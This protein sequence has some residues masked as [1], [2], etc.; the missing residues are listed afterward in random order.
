MNE[1]ET[2]RAVKRKFGPSLLKKKGVQGGGIGFK[3]VNGRKTEK[4][5]I[6]CYVE[7]KKPESSL[8]SKDFIPGQIEGIQTDVV[9]IGKF[10]ALGI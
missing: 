5:C 7:K 8:A 9:E 2:A 3:Q 4:I 10:Q 1:L 6:V